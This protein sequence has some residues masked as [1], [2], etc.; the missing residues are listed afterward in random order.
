[1]KMN[2]RNVLVGIGAIVA[3]GGAALGT[4][5]FSQVSA[6]RDVSVSVA[7]DANAFLAIAVHEDRTSGDFVEENDDGSRTIVEFDFSGD[8][9]DDG[10]NDEAVTDF[11]NLI[12]ITNNGSNDVQLNIEARDGTGDPITDLDDAFVAY[13]GDDPE[14]EIANEVLQTEDPND[15]IDVG[16]R[17]DTT[18][19]DADD[20]EDIE[21]ILITA[22]EN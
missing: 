15:S 10:L 18:E 4:G 3:G 22:E 2:R 13:E 11:H 6:E 20:V 14:S 19:A 7:D 5:A 1:M 17:F 8:T 21:T 16:F 12:T 9:N